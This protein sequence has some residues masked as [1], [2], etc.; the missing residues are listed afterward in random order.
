MARP[1]RLNFAGA[2]YHLYGRGNGRLRT[3]LDD[4]DYR[5]FLALLAR[6]VSERG[7]L[8]REY[9]LMPNH[10]H[11]IMETPEANLSRGMQRLLLSYA[12]WFNRRHRRSG[13]VFQGRYGA[14]LVDRETHLLE[15][16]RYVVLNP[17]RAGLVARPSEWTW[18]SY[19]AA[20]GRE[21]R[22]PW[23]A[24]DWILEQLDPDPRRARRAFERFVLAGVSA[25]APWKQVR[26]QIYLGGPAFL[27]RMRRI[28]PAAAPAGVPRAQLDPDR[29]D[30]ERVL[31]F[32]AREFR[33]SRPEILRRRE[34]PAF[35]ATIYLLRRGA[36]LSLAEVGKL[37]GV[38]NARITQVQRKLDGSK[39]GAR[40]RRLLRGQT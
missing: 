10:Y 37:C 5:R 29:P 17:V 13:H 11:L 20:T 22:P 4:Q 1:L 40:L 21:E 8:L 12:Q 23:L 32:V 35:E 31:A 19:N 27:A 3:F 38:S 28:R 39:E 14:I 36:G 25:P 33:L 30:Q 26:A 6:E 16:I 34:R 2:V 9:V 24:V 18:S 7:W 15:L